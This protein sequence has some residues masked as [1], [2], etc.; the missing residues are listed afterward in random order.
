MGKPVILVVEDELDLIQVY[1][2]YLSVTFSQYEVLCVSNLPTAL[3]SI[4]DLKESNTPVKV[5]IV[6]YTLGLSRGTDVLRAM[7]ES[8]PD[9]PMYLLTGRATPEVAAQAT[10]LGATVL[11]KPVRMVDL[12]KLIGA[13]Q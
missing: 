10:E 5:A 3:S 4:I 13:L 7:N 9:T 2:E 12:A 11:W 8:H 1:D 6:D